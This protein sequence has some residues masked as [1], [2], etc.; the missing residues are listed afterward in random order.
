LQ[1]NPEHLGK[2]NLSLQSKDGAMTAQFVVQNELTK[3]A[4]ESQIFTLKETLEHQGIKVETIEVTVANYG[5]DQNSHTGA[6]KEQ[7]KQNNSPGR[8]IT[9]EEAVSM[10]ELPQEE[11]ITE[12]ITGLR[13]SQIDYQA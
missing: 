6:N 9:M 8:K 3:E 4:I 11:T 2:V 13:G 1:L 5:F 10:S 12:N 7:T